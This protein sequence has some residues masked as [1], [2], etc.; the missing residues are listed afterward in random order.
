LIHFDKQPLR[1]AIVISVVVHVVGACAVAVAVGPRLTPQP[2]PL[3]VTFLGAIAEENL[4]SP[5]VSSKES[6]VSRREV[7]K[8]VFQDRALD[9]VWE[10]SLEDVARALP[11]RDVRIAER[12]QGKRFFRVAHQEAVKAQPLSSPR[13]FEVEGPA[14]SR[15]VVYVPE[16]GE[17]FDV[18]SVLLVR[19]IEVRV[20]FW[21]SERGLVIQTA[22][23]QSSGYPIADVWASRYLLQCRFSAVQES[24]SEENGWGIA[25]LPLTRWAQTE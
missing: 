15:A 12:S 7:K 11:Q 21:I 16:M 14:A 23:E 20:K 2:E 22:P 13:G 10:S 25:T 24:A 18:P 6:L 9:S 8:R 3:A 5:L 17:V 1:D 19:D 4:L